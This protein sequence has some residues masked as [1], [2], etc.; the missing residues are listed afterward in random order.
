M[1]LRFF[2]ALPQTTVAT[3]Y[4]LSKDIPV[5]AMVVE[6]PIS[7]ASLADTM[8][9]M[10]SWLD[11]HQCTPVLFATKSKQAGSVLIH[12]EFADAAD[13]GTFQAAFGPAEPEASAAVA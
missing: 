6:I 5:A 13:A 9:R 4:Q 10:R 8:G 11:E 7:A 12:V 2:A 1:R 3:I